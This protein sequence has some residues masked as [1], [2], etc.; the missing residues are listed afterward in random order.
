[1]HTNYWDIGTSTTMFG[2]GQQIHAVNSPTPHIMD[3][4][5]SHI[6]TLII[7]KA[8][9]Q[10]HHT[11]ENLRAF[12]Q[13]KWDTAEA[14]I[15]QNPQLGLLHQYTVEEELKRLSEQLKP[16]VENLL[17]AYGMDTGTIGNTITPTPKDAMFRNPNMHT[18]QSKPPS[19]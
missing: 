17:Q 11:M 3:N 10:A 14:F 12:I 5:N 7:Q 1:M 15:K 18:I 9:D 19:A 6:D 13:A 8:L 4:P 2:S 16:D